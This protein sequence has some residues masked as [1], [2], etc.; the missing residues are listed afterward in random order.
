MASFR[1]ETFAKIWELGAKFT[2]RRTRET[3]VERLNPG[4]VE[5][6]QQM[7]DLF[8]ECHERAADAAYFGHDHSRI[9]LC[10]AVRIVIFWR[11]GL[12]RALAHSL[13]ADRPSRTAKFSTLF[14]FQSRNTSSYQRRS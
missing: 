5:G 2:P 9:Y 7:R 8:I 1:P 6:F 4:S 3:L 10:G 12:R 11:G 14:E 13:R